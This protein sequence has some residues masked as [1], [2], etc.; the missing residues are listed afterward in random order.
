MSNIY[1]TIW[2]HSLDQRVH[3]T[4]RDNGVESSQIEKSRVWL[5]NC[6]NSN[7]KFKKQKIN[8]DLTVD[9]RWYNSMIMIETKD[10][11]KVEDEDKKIM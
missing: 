8:F 9:W 6:L 11:I 7:Q 5:L 2:V 4:L 10:E 1:K 3:L